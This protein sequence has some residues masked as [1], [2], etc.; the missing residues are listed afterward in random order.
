MADQRALYRSAASGQVQEAASTQ[1]FLLVPSQGLQAALPTLALGQM[2][3][4]TDTGNLF[5]GTPGVGIGFIQ[6][7]DTTRVNETLLEILLEMRAMRLALTKLAC[8]GGGN[9]RDFDP[10]AL[11]SDSE[12]ADAQN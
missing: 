10:Q 7:G 8:E 12:V 2:Y 9:P 1:P 3:F 4:A 11:A 6:I 5:F